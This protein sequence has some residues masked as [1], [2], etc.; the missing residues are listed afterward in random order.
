LIATHGDSFAKVAREAV[1]GLLC[2][3]EI[4]QG[5][6]GIAEAQSAVR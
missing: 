4:I 1:D 6:V 3:N 5:A 2:R